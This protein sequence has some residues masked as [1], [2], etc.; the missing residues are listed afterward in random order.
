MSSSEEK[1]GKSPQDQKRE[2]DRE[3]IIMVLRSRIPEGSGPGCFLC[4]LIVEDYEK[5]GML[6]DYPND[7]NGK[8]TFPYQGKANH[9]RLEL[10]SLDSL[11]KAAV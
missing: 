4:R 5:H 9:I 10:A 1:K 8:G 6:T 3:R 7:S 11:A 2:S